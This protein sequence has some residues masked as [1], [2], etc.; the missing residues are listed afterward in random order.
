[1]E[2]LSIKRLTV[3]TI[4]FGLSQATLIQVEPKHQMIQANGF[5]HTK[6]IKQVDSPM[7]QGQT[8]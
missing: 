1:M 4:L 2:S 7:E 6:N 3:A 8:L 5:T